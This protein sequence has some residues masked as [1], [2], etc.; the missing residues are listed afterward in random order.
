MG[1]QQRAAHERKD[2]KVEGKTNQ[3][4]VVMEISNLYFHLFH[5]L[6]L[7][8]PPSAALAEPSHCLSG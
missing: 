4:L 8:P 5:P 2:V 6:C 7:S 1:E 3:C